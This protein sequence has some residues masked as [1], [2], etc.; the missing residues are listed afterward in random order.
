MSRLIFRAPRAH[1]AWLVAFLSLAPAL[2]AQAR[3]TRPAPARAAA[4]AADSARIR[5]DIAYL[6]DDR[7]EGRLTGTPGNDSAAA[8]IARRFQALALRPIVVGPADS[9]RCAA[10]RSAIG[11]GTVQPERCA[12]YV[13]RFTARVA[14]FAHVGQPFELPTQNVVALIPGRDPALRGQVV[15]LGAHY[16]HLG[17]DTL[18]ATDPR[19]GR[20]IHNGAD[21]NASGTAAVMELARLIAANPT[22]RSVLVVA[23]SGE[24]EGTLGSQW[25]V[26]HSPVPMDS[27]V[28][29]L[30]F[31]M[32]GRLT[33][34]RLLVYG[35]ATAAELPRIVDSTNAAGPTLAVKALGD[36]QGPSD[37]ATFYLKNLPVLHFFTDQHPDYHAATDDV[38]KINAAGEARVVDL[39]LGITRTIGDR[40]ARLTFKRAPARVASGPESA[41]GPRP[42]LG[43][44]PDMAA[45]DAGGLKLVG[46]TP[47]SPADKGGLKS[48]DVIVEFDGKPVK[49]LYTY[50]DALYA[51]KPGDTVQ[52][53]VKR[54]GVAGATGRVT[55]SVTLGRRGE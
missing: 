8:Y 14:A 48:G 9:A 52:I 18:F 34:D 46:I 30:N 44:V 29:M 47:D 50:S 10:N 16:D 23:F 1:A 37:H 22:R 38:E 21:D 11:A 27:I 13:Q 7:L 4:R 5:A 53:V 12:G 54:A 55:L 33:D 19:A 24:E 41:S 51:R 20:V 2:G 6:A 25:F 3:Q 39:A 17:R 32:V 28:A 49:D 26:D 35:V 36:G 31:D 45:D 40:P 43:S 15:V 42:Y